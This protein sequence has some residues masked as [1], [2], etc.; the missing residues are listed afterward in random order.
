QDVLV[1]D[2]ILDMELYLNDGKGNF[3]TQFNPFG[4]LQA[5][6]TLNL[7]GYR[8][9]DAVAA[10]L[11]GDGFTDLILTLEPPAGATNSLLILLN[12]KDGTFGSASLI[13]PPAL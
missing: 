9:L 7:I 6:G 3:T 4:N 8:V 13:T 5:I 1:L 10:D 11:N 12:Q 2:Y